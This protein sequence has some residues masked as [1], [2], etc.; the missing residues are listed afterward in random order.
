[1]IADR[2]RRTRITRRG[3]H[4]DFVQPLESRLLLSGG[5]RGVVYDDLNANGVRDGGEPGLRDA[6]VYVDLDGNGAYTNNEPTAATDDVGA[7]F[8]TP[9]HLTFATGP[10]VTVGSTPP[11]G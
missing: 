11:T 1:M 7:Y 5:I 10:L 3:R 2:P 4:A 8:L 9:E 6:L